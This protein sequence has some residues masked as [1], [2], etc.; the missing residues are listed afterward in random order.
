MSKARNSH[1][2]ASRKVNNYYITL[3]V[4]TIEMDILGPLSLALEGTILFYL[5][6]ITLLSR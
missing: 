5:P 4:F 6:V 2:P 3:A 1:S